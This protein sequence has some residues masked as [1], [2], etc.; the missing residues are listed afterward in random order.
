M[1]KDLFERIQ[2]NKGPLGKWASQAEGYYVFPKLEG[3]LGP[4]M[5]FHG[6]EILN[7]SLNDYLGLA[8]HPEVRKAD[9]QAA[10]DWGAAY[11]M[12]AR[13]MS[14]HTTIHEQLQNELAEFVGKEAAYLL[15][16]GYQGMVSTIDAL[17]TKNDVIVYDVDSHACIID[18]VRLHMG[19][20]FTY[21]HNDMESIEKNLQRATKMAEE[22]GGGILFI[23]E[24]VF[25]M[26]GQQGKLKEIVALKE[27]YNFRLLVD[28][29]HGFG[30]LGK[31]GAG[32]G[33]EQGCQDGIDV[34]FSTFAKSMASI[35][36]FIAG[37]KDII[38][39]L[40]YNLRS[41]MF[42]KSLP[43]IQTIG[44]L[45]RL[46]MLRTMP[47]LKAKL[48]ENVDALQNGLK[49]R[50]FNIGDTNT[51]V[52]PVYLE[53]SIPEAMVMVNDLRENYGIF[54]SIVVYPVIPKGIILLRMIPTASHS[55]QDIE[56]TLAAF[57][58]I[59]EKLTNGTYKQIAE[60]NVENV[61]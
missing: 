48:W 29:A 3:E 46:E 11:P 34:Y 7:W 13:M 51:C 59:R 60:A 6:K 39:Y 44:A 53:G 45:K 50:G 32:A 49:E 18:G 2:Q 30:T 26:R 40:K 10:A 25:G 54:L 14:G 12:G 8:N 42:A 38:D 5:K 17:V 20:R 19:K 47:E 27:K 1:V 9:A 43:M 37:D 21:K 55:L 31:T 24:G 35:G 56:E 52:T 41:Q 61:E 23:T 58:A 4:H 16:F 57:E 28:D 36:A 15:N 22:T 33:E